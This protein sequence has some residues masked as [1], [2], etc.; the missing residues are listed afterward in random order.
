MT[1]MDRGSDELEQLS[2][3]EAYERLENDNDSNRSDEDLEDYALSHDR[4]ESNQ[5]WLSREGMM[6][7]NDIL[8]NRMN[9]Q[10]NEFNT[11]N[12]GDIDQMMDVD[13]GQSFDNSQNSNAKR[14][15]KQQRINHSKFLEDKGI[16]YQSQNFDEL[17][18]LEE[19]KKQVNDSGSKNKETPVKERTYLEKCKI[20]GRIGPVDAKLNIDYNSG[21]LK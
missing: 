5:N 21:Q 12:D 8:G 1:E 16:K 3:E 9:H 17:K 18:N 13:E 10:H 4:S 6:N 11:D 7:E 2:S 15:E 19:E 14:L 20:V